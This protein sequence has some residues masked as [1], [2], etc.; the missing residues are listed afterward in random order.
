MLVI[1]AGSYCVFVYRGLVR[2]DSVCVGAVS[3]GAGADSLTIRR[4]PIPIRGFVGIAVVVVVVV[5]VAVG[6]M[7]IKERRQQWNQY[8]VVVVVVG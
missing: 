1:F 3:A 4:S 5:A 7:R 8:A 6:R 2:A